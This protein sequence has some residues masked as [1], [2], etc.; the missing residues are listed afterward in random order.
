MTESFDDFLERHSADVPDR[1]PY[2]LQP[3][4][5]ER[6]AAAWWNSKTPGERYCACA[7]GQ[8]PTKVVNDGELPCVIVGWGVVGEDAAVVSVLTQWEKIANKHQ[9]ILLKNMR[10]GWIN[11]R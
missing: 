5:T 7:M 11:V 2:T 1:G 4:L 6:Q 10:E 8:S 3:N 9:S